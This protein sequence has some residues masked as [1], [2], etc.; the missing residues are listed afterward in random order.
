VAARRLAAATQADLVRL[1]AG[2]EALGRA[3]F[4]ARVLDRVGALLPRL[5]EADPDQRRRLLDGS[6]LD[7]RI[8]LNLLHLHERLRRRPDAASGSLSTLLRD[9]AAFFR[10]RDPVDRAL[11]P[12]LLARLDDALA[13]VGDAKPSVSNTATLL[14]L[15]GMRRALFP[16]A[17]RP[18]VPGGAVVPPAVRL[19]PAA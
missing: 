1:A 4:E 13:G 10:R 17:D 19:E 3:R 6:L 7:L 14:A 5:R 9:L 2:D 15:A 12:A 8:G 16:D 11:P 18:N